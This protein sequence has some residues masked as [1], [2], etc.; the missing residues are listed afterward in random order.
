ML[1]TATVFRRNGE[2]ALHEP[3][4]RANSDEAAAERMVNK[5]FG[6]PLERPLAMRKRHDGY[7]HINTGLVVCVQEAGAVHLEEVLL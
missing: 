5:Y 3:A 7:E 1:Y 6:A 4:I 2:L